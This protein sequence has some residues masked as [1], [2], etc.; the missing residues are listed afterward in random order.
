MTKQFGGFVTGL[1]MGLTLPAQAALF[2]F[3]VWDFN[4]Y[5]NDGSTGTLLPSVGNGQVNPV[6]GT[7]LKF[8]FASGS[9]EAGPD[10]SA[11]R[12]VAPAGANVGD[13]IGADF[14]IPTIGY[15]QIQ[16]R[17][18]RLR[19]ADSPQTFQVEY[20]YDDGGT[21]SEYGTFGP[22]GSTWGVGVEGFWSNST[23]LDLRGD[24]AADNHPGLRF[25]V[26][27]TLL[28]DVASDETVLELDRVIAFVDV[29]TPVPEPT[30]LAMAVGLVALTAGRWYWRR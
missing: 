17:F 30:A 12:L 23:L 26:Q 1:L 24:T 11:L 20:S 8:G 3:A 25:R 16:L 6:G 13:S 18:D 22:S 28:S 2:D 27:T 5:D 7:L 10:N 9:S 14:T 19:P 15:S 21:W 4:T 29:V